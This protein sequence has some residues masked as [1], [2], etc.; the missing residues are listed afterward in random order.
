MHTGAGAVPVIVGGA[1]VSAGELE[2]ADIVHLF[3]A[4]LFVAGIRR[5][6]GR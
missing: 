3:M 6:T 5:S 4:D 2:S 1:M